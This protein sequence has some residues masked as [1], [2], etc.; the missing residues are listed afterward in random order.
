MEGRRARSILT[1]RRYF[2]V[3]ALVLVLLVAEVLAGVRLWDKY[4]DTQLSMQKL[5]SASESIRYLDEVLSSSALLAALTG[6]AHWNL[7]YE[8]SASDLARVF[9]G[10][11]EIY[12]GA[13][14]IIAQTAEANDRLLELEAQALGLAGD[15]RTAEATALLSGDEYAVRKD[16]YARGIEQLEAGILGYAQR[17]DVRLGREVSFGV[18]FGA[19]VLLAMGTALT[20]VLRALSDRLSA[21]RTLGDLSV[22]LSGT[23][24]EL[25]DDRIAWALGRLRSAAGG[26][27]A[28]LLMHR[29]D[30]QDAPKAHGDTSLREW[31]TAGSPSLVEAAGRLGEHDGRAVMVEI[32]HQSLE[33]EAQGPGFVYVR[34]TRNLPD[35][36]EFARELLAQTQIRSL[37]GVSLD[38]EGGYSCS[39]IIAHD[40]GLLR[41]DSQDAAVMR[42]SAEVLLHVVE[43]A[44][45]EQ[46][47][48]HLARFDHLTGIANRAYFSELL[49]SEIERVQRLGQSAA[50][51]MMDIDHFKQ[52]ND[53][54]GHAAGDDVLVQMSRR[55]VGALRRIDVVGRLGGEE[56]GVLLP[57]SDMASACV[58]AERL[59]SAVAA[60]A[61]HA[62]G[63][64]LRLTVSVGATLLVRDDETI[65]GPLRRADEALYGAK[66]AGRNRVV[67]D[68]LFSGS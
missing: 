61:F 68:E 30:T 31:V 12:P 40:S 55:F 9:E 66:H 38:H 6:D 41:W 43:N 8:R 60:E 32:L 1:E 14:D 15:G 27:H 13:E 65:D 16:E 17:Q 37:L 35:S 39:L 50:L 18:A 5:E 36:A 3:L 23:S 46:R 4:R 25:V 10:V 51:L 19:L 42:A 11:R 7:R 29:A 20:Y 26:E 33:L 58:A 47:L 56:F 22:R 44:D 48:R 62:E 57:G 45:Q 54:H 63:A 59:R 21:E 67:C 2:G 52:V 49:Q 34:D 53:D 28:Y 24:T 64:R